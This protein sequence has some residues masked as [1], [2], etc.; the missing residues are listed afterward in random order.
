M[1]SEQR[2]SARNDYNLSLKNY[3]IGHH[4]FRKSKIGYTKI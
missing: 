4:V 2:L 3:K 1:S